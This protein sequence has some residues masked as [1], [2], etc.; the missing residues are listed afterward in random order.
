[1]LWGL[2]LCA[3][4]SLGATPAPPDN[5]EQA[6]ILAVVDSYMR[7]ITA[8]DLKRMAELQMAEGMT[9]VDRVVDGR[10]RI[11]ARSNAYWVEP[12][13]KSSV[14]VRERY[15][16]PTVLVRGSIALVW[17]P[18]EFWRDGKVA[19]CGIDTFDMVK[20]EGQWRVAN[21][22]WTVEPDACAELRP[23]DPSQIR[24]RD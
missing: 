20:V 3:A 4:S 2:L 24:P 1:M 19:H 16:N 10:R 9:F 21:S 11:V 5:G 8:D 6:A 17:T 22:M 14:P 23:A 13:R 18:Y 7:A 12:A 15:W